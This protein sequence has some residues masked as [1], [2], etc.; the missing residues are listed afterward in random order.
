MD[1]PF[2]D[3]S[4]LPMTLLAREVRRDVTVALG[5]DGGDE[6]LGGYPT[7]VVDEALA[8]MPAWP[9]KVA[10]AARLALRALPHQDGNL[11][12]SFRASQLTQGLSWSG[13]RRHAAWLAPL[14]PHDL[15]RLAGPRLAEASV[16]RAF[17]AV[18][19][20]ARATGTRFDAATSFYLKLYLGEGVLAKVDRATMRASLEAR[21]PLLDTGVAEFCL[22]LPLR[23]R[24][25]GFTTKWLMREAMKPLVPAS[26]VGRPKKGFGAPVGQW[27]RGP[28][29]SLAKETLAADR[30]A[31]GGWL[32]PKGVAEMMSAH[33]EGRS[34]LRKPL[35]AAVVFEH[36]RQRSG[37]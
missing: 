11:S 27:L 3:S 26:I 22:T 1:E 6:L 15:S 37:L 16:T 34:D 8:H 19:E 30:L 21:A 4:L 33:L 29:R 7:F 12:L 32:D 18:D 17:D 24:V 20:A 9:T 28:L 25:R 35:W 31:E 13:A 36:W 10:E 14:L 2:A 5:G 23:F